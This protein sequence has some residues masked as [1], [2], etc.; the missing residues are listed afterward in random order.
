MCEQARHLLQ[1]QAATCVCVGQGEPY[2]SYERGIRPLLILLRQHPEQLCGAQ[3]A[4]KVVGKAAALLFCYGKIG[5]L[6]AQVLSRP[7]KE[8]LEKEGIAFSYG[9]LVERIR[10]RTGD[11]LCPM[12]ERAMT[13]DSPA[14]AYEM[15]SEIVK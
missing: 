5:Q 15:F 10:N 11:G 13:V 12:E 6:Y 3:V 1:T 7:A 8:V 2:I 4:D 9:S 14:Q